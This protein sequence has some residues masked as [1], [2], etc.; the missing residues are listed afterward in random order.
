ML[1]LT[2]APAS[3]AAQ[4]VPPSVAEAIDSDAGSDLQPFYAARNYRPLWIRDGA[5]GPEAKSLLALLKS[6]DL[7]GLDSGRYRPR[8]IEKAIEKSD[9]GTAESLARV[10][11]LLSRKFVAYVRD[12]RR[13]RRPVMI[14]VDKQLAPRPP[15]AVE[16]LSAA[17][18]A[19]SLQAYLDSM[20][21]MHP[22]YAQLRAALAAYREPS[23][24]AEVEVPAGPTLGPGAA[25]E[26]VELLRR[27]LGLPPGERFDASVA[28]ALRTF[29]AAR[30]I[31]ADGRAGARTIAA[32]NADTRAQERMLRV[33][34]NRA[35]ALPADPGRHVIVNAA[36]GRLWTYEN[37]RIRDSMRVVVGRTTDPTP[38]MAALIRFAMVNPYWNVPPDLVA[39]RIAPHVLSEGIPY[40]AEKKYEVLSDWSERAT[41]LDAAQIDWKAVADGKTELRVRQLPGP[42][43]AMG[44][45]KLMFPNAMGIYLHDTPEKA[46][47]KEPERMFSAG[48]VRLEDA[49]R[50]AKWLFGKPLL[51]R[52]SAPEQKVDLPRPV[53]VYLTYLTAAPEDGVIVFHNDVYD[54]DSGKRPKP[55]PTSLASR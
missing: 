19:P 29:Q 24:D 44:R 47:L 45:M 35:R 13:M 38:M 42:V 48:C 54:R 40:L 12:A 49:P 1:A 4:P 7:D 28:A 5:V 33:N 30:N 53:P 36:A 37:R 8:T 46:L 39:T 50:L 21:W 51:I 9:D 3:A 23:G 26:P 52:S 11:L 32:L 25:G 2:P 10:E 14:Y 43:N 55:A 22:I 18:A 34:L 15:G 31:P 6:A 17:A 16:L 20:A 27:R 41:P